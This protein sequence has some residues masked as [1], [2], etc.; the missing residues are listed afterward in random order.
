MSVDTKIYRSYTEKADIVKE[1]DA[2]L[3][4][5]RDMTYVCLNLLPHDTPQPIVGS[6]KTIHRNILLYGR[7]KLVQASYNCLAIMM[8]SLASV[9]INIF[10]NASTFSLKSHT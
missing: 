5:F 4:I 3:E 8:S 9:S 2:E 7:S 1:I 10:A 6:N